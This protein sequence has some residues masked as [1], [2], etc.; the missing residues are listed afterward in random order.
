MT[1]NFVDVDDRYYLELA[2]RPSVLG[3]VSVAM[4]N[5][6]FMI[7]GSL[8][9]LGTTV[10]HLNTSQL[11]NRFR[12]RINSDLL[13][14]ELQ[15]NVNASDRE[16]ACRPAVIFRV[17]RG[18]VLETFAVDP[19]TG[20]L[21]VVRPLN[22]IRCSAYQLTVEV[23]CYDDCVDSDDDDRDVTFARLDVVI[24]VTYDDN[25]FTESQPTELLQKSQEIVSIAVREDV[26]IGAVVFAADTVFSP[27]SVS[28]LAIEGP[29]G[30]VT[31]W[32]YSIDVQYCSTT[33]A[34]GAT[35]E[36]EC[37]VVTVDPETGHVILASRLN[38]DDGRKRIVVVVGVGRE[39]KPENGKSDVTTTGNRC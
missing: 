30:T 37:A 36:F 6:S 22:H 10:G 11:I 7:D 35:S 39:V 25:G 15:N 3:L 24:H 12:Q 26:P 18:N 32:R 19:T 34:G 17:T 31:H 16:R 14:D 38:A 13:S 4:F 1:V 5:V 29:P 33:P 23:T 9:S 21:Y 20:R 27:R 2:D 28:H 8:S